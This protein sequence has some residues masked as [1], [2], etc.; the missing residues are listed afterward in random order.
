MGLDPVAQNACSVAS[1][2]KSREN[3]QGT[4]RDRQKHKENPSEDNIEQ[5][6]G[7]IKQG[8]LIEGKLRDRLADWK[9]DWMIGQPVRD[10][11]IGWSTS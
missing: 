5:H 9:E 1:Q 4:Q 10:W 3:Q 7:Y 11:K 8:R 6:R 2:C